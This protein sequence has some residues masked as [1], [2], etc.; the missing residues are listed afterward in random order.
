M[1]PLS[2][3]ML[4]ESI[5]NL[6]LAADDE[7]RR[8]SKAIGA[9]L[10]MIP[11]SMG[12]GK[13][14]LAQAGT[15]S[16]SDLARLVG[17]NF[18]WTEEG[19]GDDPRCWTF[20]EGRLT[21]EPGGQIELSSAVFPTAS[22]LIDSM[23]H[24]TGELINAAGQLGIELQTR[25]I[26]PR[27]PIE[28]VPLQLHRERYEKMTRYFESLGPY[29]ILMMRQTASLQINVDR[30]ERPLE[31]W[32]LL[33]SLAPY[34][35]AIFSNSS[36][37]AGAETGHKSYRAHVWRNLDSRRTGLAYGEDATEHYLDFALNAPVILE[38]QGDR[39]PAFR[40]LLAEGRASQEMW[41]VHLTTLFP[42]IRPREYFEIRS[43]DAISPQNLSAAVCLVAGLTYGN[44]SSLTAAELGGKP[45]D[46]L[47][48]RAGARGLSDPVVRAVAERLVEVALDGCASLGV[49]YIA[50]DHVSEA[51]AFFERYTLLGRSPADD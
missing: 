31:R 27:N 44:A 24:W 50:R 36:R 26:D 45:D 33:N 20:P 15:P 11:V 32:L 14:I 46:S 25:G 30:G 10:E 47:L 17:R 51:K 48:V 39:Y 42:E 21:F 13:R 28:T 22:Q 1:T 23:K 38:R 41:E 12:T 43:I 35:V 37:Y 40:D 3:D 7:A 18:G 9:E 4:R 49:E 8:K 16:G 34:F 29:G 5:R 6:F 19:M 2:L